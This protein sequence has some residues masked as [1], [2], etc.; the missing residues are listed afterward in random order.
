M[1][2][3]DDDPIGPNERFIRLV[4]CHTFKGDTPGQGW[5]KP[6]NDETTGISMFRESCLDNPIDCLRAISDCEKRDYY[7]VVAYPFCAFESR[8]MSF[9]R[10]QINEVPG[11][12]LLSEITPD[13]WKADENN[14]RY[15]IPEL[16]SDTGRFTIRN[17]LKVD[18]K[19]IPK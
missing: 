19:P 18:F 11:H 14:L 4:W 5:F 17:P 16:A 12:V 13:S 10:D 15:R 3:P 7:A 1:A 9:I 6:R 8:Q 2:T